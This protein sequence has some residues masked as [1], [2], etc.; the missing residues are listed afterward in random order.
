M[1]ENKKPDLPESEATPQSDQT[2]ENIPEAASGDTMQ[3]PVIHEDAQPEPEIPPMNNK[4][5]E[6]TRVYDIVHDPEVTPIPIEKKHKKKNKRRSNLLI[7]ILACLVVAIIISGIFVGGALL[8]IGKGIIDTAPDLDVSDFVSNES[9]K[10]YDGNGE[11]IAELGAYLREN[12]TYDEC[13]EALV[14]AFVSIEDSRFFEHFGFD[15]PRFSKAIIENLRS[16]SFAQGGSTFTMQ[17]V[18]NTYFQVDDLNSG[19]MAAKSI[20]RK[21]QEIWLA[22]NLEKK[23]D[24]KRIFELYMNKLNFGNNIRGVQ[25]AALYYFNKEVKDLNTSE[26]ALLAG[27]INQPNGYNPYYHLDSATKRRNE[28]LNM[29]AY[30]GYITES[31]A[32]MAK[33]IKVEDQLAGEQAANKN[34]D[35]SAYQSYIDAAIQE[36]Q[37][38]TGKDPSLVGMTIYTYMDRGVQET[39]DSIQ[40]GS[41]TIQFPDDLMQIAIC[42]MN[43]RTGAVVGVGGGRGYNAARLLNRATS[44]YKQPGSSVKPLLSY[45]LAFEHLGWSLEHIVVDRPITYPG[46]SRVL[47][48]FDGE[49]RGDVMIKDAVGT[50][51]N[52]PAILTLKTVEDEIGSRRIVSYMQSLG[53]TR[54]SNEKYHLSYAIGGGTFETTP[55]ELAGAHAAMINAGVY[56]KPHTIEKIEMQDGTVYYPEDQNRKVL[57]AGSAWMVT[58]L[59]KNNVS[60]PYFNYMQILRSE[61]P[62]YAKTG[63]TDWGTEGVQYGIPKGAAKDKWMVSSTNQYTNV[64][65]VGYDMGV[66]DKGCYFSGYKSQLNIPGNINRLLLNSEEAISDETLKEGVKKPE[67]DL[68]MITYVRGTYPYATYED[69]MDPGL[70]VTTEVSK[71]GKKETVDI[72]EHAQSQEFNGVSATVYADGALQISWSVGDGFCFDDQKDISL[73][74]D[75]NDIEAYGAC[76]FD[77][78]W[79]IGNDG[80]FGAQVFVNDAYIGDVYG[81]NAFYLGYP[82]DTLSGPVKVCGFYG[83]GE[84]VSEQKCVIASYNGG[85]YGVKYDEWGNPYWE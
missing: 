46:E 25:K 72:R 62:V 52:I 18:K 43:N 57:S 24:K 47:V 5:M 34:N 17:L 66:K 2:E 73:H 3:V 23:I 31:E 70:K 59:E 69:W 48:N 84:F 1:E 51:L 29:M 6:E 49:Y 81:E 26:C 7:T 75:Y 58:E 22:I 35:S 76:L 50:S 68:E 30:H 8:Y 63:T 54:V 14:D 56:N 82:G 27:L 11:L 10:M 39:I 16:G 44:Q 60:G 42:S 80:M 12:I 65:W 40:D 28:V 74:D 15:I 45:A 53:F 55:F 19:T 37:A 9:T 71:T 85:F 67:D 77:Y 20:D 38:I 64:V 33:S 78:S 21:V 36:A 83:S 61:Y 32:E 41:S 79:L 4:P 13:P